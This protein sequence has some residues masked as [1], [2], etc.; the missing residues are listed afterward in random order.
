MKELPSRFLLTVILISSFT[1]AAHSSTSEIVPG[2]EARQDPP[3]EAVYDYVHY[4]F[5]GLCMEERDAILRDHLVKEI[6]GWPF[7]DRIRDHRLFAFPKGTNPMH[8][9]YLLTVDKGLTVWPLRDQRD[10]NELLQVE[11]IRI[12]SKEDALD[13]AQ[14][15]LKCSRIRNVLYLGYNLGVNVIESVDDIKFETDAEKVALSK[16]FV[17]RPPQL[18]KEGECFHYTLFSWE[19]EGSG[20]LERHDLLIDD[21]G[22]V[23]STSVLL[24][25]RVGSWVGE[26]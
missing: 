9:M 7:Q 14:L 19:P 25:N 6:Q 16:E 8:G 26:R 20:A 17:V 12:E 2:G 1:V 3:I 11:G 21:K 24:R 15:F 5:P 10:F 18:T 22:I 23:K 13:A 4:Q